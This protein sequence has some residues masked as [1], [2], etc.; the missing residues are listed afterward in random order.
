[1]DVFVEQKAGGKLVLIFNN[2]S[3]D[4]FD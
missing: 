4:F 3:D 1:M 2:K